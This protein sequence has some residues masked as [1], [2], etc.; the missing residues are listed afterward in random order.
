MYQA[1]WYLYLFEIPSDFVEG[2]LESTNIPVGWLFGGLQIACAGTQRDK[3]F[4]ST[5]HLELNVDLELSSLL[6]GAEGP[7]LPMAMP[8]DGRVHAQARKKWR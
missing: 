7:G 4:D 1:R 6:S 3:A 2:P 5:I 8:P